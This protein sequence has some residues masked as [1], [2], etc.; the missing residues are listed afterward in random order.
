[1]SKFPK[2]TLQN[3]RL[4]SLLGEGG[5]GKVWLAEQRSP[6]R[7]VAIKVIE[8]DEKIPPIVLKKLAEEGDTAAQFEHDNLVQVIEAGIVDGHYFLVMQYLP[9]GTLEERLAKGGV[10][11]G[12]IRDIGVKIAGALG[13]IHA[14]GYIHRDVKPANILFTAKGKPVLADF[15]VA[16]QADSVGALT[17]AGIS[18]GTP[19]YMSPEQVSGDTLDGRSDLYS[20]G[21]VLFEALTGAPPFRGSTSHEIKQAHLNDVPEMLPGHEEFQPIVDRLLAKLPHKRFENADALVEALSVLEVGNGFVAERISESTAECANHST[22]TQWFQDLKKRRVFRTAAIYVALAWGFTEIA[23]TVADTYEAPQWI[24]KA[25]V[26]AFVAGFPIAVLLAWL[27]DLRVVRSQP[28]GRGRRLRTLRLLAGLTVVSAVTVGLYWLLANFDSKDHVPEFGFPT[29]ITSLEGFERYPSLSP[30]GGHVAFSLQKGKD[31]SASRIYVMDL[32]SREPI[33][34]SDRDDAFETAPAWSPDGT[35]VVFIRRR[36]DQFFD[37][38]KKPLVGGSEGSIIPKPIRQHFENPPDAYKG[39]Y[40]IDFSPDGEVLA[41]PDSDE[42]NRITGIYFLDLVTGE[43]TRFTFPESNWYDTNPR[44]SPDGTTLTFLRRQNAGGYMARACIKNIKRPQV[45]C[46]TDQGLYTDVDWTPDSKSILVS[47][48]LPNAPLALVDIASGDRFDV[49]SVVSSFQVTVSRSAS[50]LIYSAD[51]EDYDLWRLPGPK[52]AIGSEASPIVRS[53]KIDT[54]GTFSPDGSKIAFMST[55]LGSPEVWIAEA[56]GSKP[57]QI[58]DL[59]FSTHPEWSPDGSLILFNGCERAGLCDAYS[60]SV[61]GGLVTNVTD[62]EME[63]SIPSWTGDGNSIL[64]QATSEE[65]GGRQLWI[66]RL[67]DGVGKQI[68]SCVLRPREGPDGRVYFWDF[69]NKELSSIN[70]DGDDLRSE[71]KNAVWHSWSFWED[72]LVFL[73]IENT[74]EMLNL[75]TRNLTQI[76]PA[77]H[78]ENSVTAG[79]SVDPDGTWILHTKLNDSGSDLSLVPITMDSQ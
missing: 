64:T 70:I 37:L 31:D 44:F 28:A 38:V 27:Y 57:R 3:Y 7:K 62:D 11:V 72:N 21:I 42:S 12:E 43:S 74:I 79:L 46:L 63:D 53:T 68:A 48:P 17:K 29:P 47:S 1:M 41:V 13:S 18:I 34:F 75:E 58:T 67:D 65:C 23:T 10:S 59:G 78:Y 16:K 77:Q 24:T 52:A 66:K 50:Q 51:Y 33:P 30:D 35:E 45:R 36:D 54:M 9:G 6:R 15:G 5:M 76:G 39:Q 20:L 2:I 69:S 73:T 56:D 40:G 32:E 49:P 60:V 26:S 22:A 71:I 19:I 61:S 14:E 25:L 4:L 55:R 8:P